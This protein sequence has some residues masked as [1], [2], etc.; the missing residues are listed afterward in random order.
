MSVLTNEDKLDIV[1]Q[2]LR[3]IDYAIYNAELDKLEAEAVENPEAGV[4]DT[5]TTRLAN[6]NSKRSVL[7]TEKE[8]LSA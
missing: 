4:I 8:S 6:L 5:L 2:H 7:I 1:N 3:S